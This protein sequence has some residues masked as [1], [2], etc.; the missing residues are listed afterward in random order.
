MPATPVFF[1]KFHPL[2]LAICTGLA[3]LAAYFHLNEDLWND[4]IYTLQS[5]VFKGLTTV[6]TDYHVPN[7]HILS[8]VLHW[9]WVKLPG[10]NKLDAVLDQAWKIRLLPALLSL[11]TI[12]V[13]WRTGDRAWGR[14]GAW[15]TILL[16]L[17]GITF[18][19]FAF[20]VRGYPLS[21]LAAAGL[22]QAAFLFLE[23]PQMSRGQWFAVAGLGA[24]LLYTIP[25]NLYLLLA[26][27][28]MAPIAKGLPARENRTANL[29]WISALLAGAALAVVL[30]WPVFGQ[31]SNNDYIAAAG[32]FRKVHAQNPMDVLTQFFSWRWLMLPVLGW[33]AH[34]ACAAT[35]LPRRRFVLLGGVLVL[36]FLLSAIR[37]DDA[38]LRAYAVLL[39]AFVL[40][41]ALCWHSAA[42][43]LS[44]GRRT[45]LNVGM[46]LIC[47]FGFGYAEYEVRVKLRHGMD[48]VVRYQELNYNYYADYYEPNLE[49]DL[50][51]QRY[52]GQTLVLETA[53]PYD[54]PVYLD[55]KGMRFVPLDSI[56]AYL[57]HEVTVYVSTRNPRSFMREMGKLHDPSWNCSCMQPMVRYPRVVVCKKK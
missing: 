16:L 41:L 31:V 42:E 38:P 9:A 34:K 46:G 43:G 33:G 27:G 56:E 52:P 26:A 36:P 11:G 21:M 32:A 25:S 12:A 29:Q 17:T 45:A 19:H 44:I 57:Q 48:E 28:A 40:L 15:I 24:A 39:P 54:Q 23:N 30:Y 10:F 13:L 35:G 20:Q 50:F 49:F 55:R 53:E 3:V 4:E 14:A 6:L 2:P 5:F 22:L 8:N 18:E 7:N 51:Q 47:L 1:Q 37:G